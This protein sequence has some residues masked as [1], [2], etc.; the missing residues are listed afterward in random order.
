MSSEIIASG[1][2]VDTEDLLVSAEVAAVYADGNE[3]GSMVEES[4]SAAV[5]KHIVSLYVKQMNADSMPVNAWTF[6]EIEEMAGE[7]VVPGV[8]G[9]AD[10]TLEE[11]V[12]MKSC[13]M[14]AFMHDGAANA[15]C[16]LRY[17]F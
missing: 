17:E 13:K 4:G 5:E 7:L 16:N 12:A 6:A 15:I 1:K 8:N 9:H 3:S 10:V 2:V 11:P 14:K